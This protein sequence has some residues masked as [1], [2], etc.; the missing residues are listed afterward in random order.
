MMMIKNVFSTTSRLGRYPNAR[1]YATISNPLVL[2]PLPYDR[3]QLE[4]LINA[5]TLDYHYGK[6]HAGYVN[7]LNTQLQGSERDLPT[8]IKTLKAKDPKSF[9]LAAQIWNHTF[10]WDSMKPVAAGG[11]KDPS[12]NI[13]IEIEKNFGNYKTFKDDFTGVAANLFGSGWAWLVKDPKTHKLSIVGTSNAD[14]PLADGL[15][16]LITCDVWE[17]AYYIQYRNERPK[18][19]DAWWKLVNW[20]FANQNLAKK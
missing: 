19:I 8:L 4:P 16:P 11:G 6:H 20:E 15:I 17:H 7:K 10:Y 3:T 2:P 18:Y 12:G 5:E 1:G 9:N 13:A 14:C